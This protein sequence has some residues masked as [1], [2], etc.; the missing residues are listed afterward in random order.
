MHQHYARHNCYPPCLGDTIHGTMTVGPRAYL[1]DG[2]RSILN[3]IPNSGP[4]RKQ[5]RAEA[6]SALRDS[7]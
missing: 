2:Y 5:R 6:P 1:G 3:F 4:N 7:H